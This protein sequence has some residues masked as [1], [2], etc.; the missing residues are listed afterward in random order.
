MLGG[1]LKVVERGLPLLYHT[2]MGLLSRGLP[3]VAGQ[4]RAAV[5]LATQHPIATSMA[6]AYVGAHAARAAARPAAHPTSQPHID[7]LKPIKGF[8][9]AAAE[10]EQKGGVK[11][12]LAGMLPGIGVYEVATGKTHTPLETGLALL[13]DV[14]W[15][16]PGGGI[17]SRTAV[18]GLE[19]VG[20]R[21]GERAV[22]RGAERIGIKTGEETALRG[23]EK[24][25]IRGAERLPAGRATAELLEQGTR[26]SART[27]PKKVG[28]AVSKAMLYGA[29]GL[30]GMGIGATLVGSGDDNTQPAPLQYRPSTQEQP[31]GL[32]TEIYGGLV[33]KPQA[34]TTYPDGTYY[35][36]T[37]GTWQ[38]PEDAGWSYVPPAQAIIQ[39]PV[40]AIKS[41]PILLGL[42]VLTVLGMGYVL[43][44]R[45]GA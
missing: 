35:D 32:P 6:G 13:G 26:I 40:G 7:V 30:T 33:G 17:I 45:V 19:R 31:T 41:S 39:D 1:L 3:K 36:P 16:V 42:V 11:G 4:A 9:E 44:K 34:A 8:Y 37:T 23:I 25:G 28:S 15:V 21:A 20:L 14:L 5:K 24:A 12:F 43:L 18:R 2:G 38:Y 22:F 29:A 27:A 10:E